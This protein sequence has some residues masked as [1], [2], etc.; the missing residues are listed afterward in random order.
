[1]FLYL[2]IAIFFFIYTYAAKTVNNIFPVDVCTYVSVRCSFQGQTNIKCFFFKPRG[3][4]DDFSRKK[5]DVSS[6]KRSCN[7]KQRTRETS[8]IGKVSKSSFV[9]I[10]VK[11]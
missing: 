2:F 6:Y 8:N 5:V 11:F 3:C 7:L 10:E 9:Q 4:V 1:M